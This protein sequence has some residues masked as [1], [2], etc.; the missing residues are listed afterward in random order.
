MANQL[1]IIVPYR[2]HGTWVF[3][4]QAVGLEREPFVTGVPEMIDEL[5]RDIPRADA[6]FRL[7]F[8]DRPFPGFQKELTWVREEYEGHWYRSDAPP[9]EGWLCPALL[10]YFDQAPRNIYVKAQPKEQNDVG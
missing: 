10:K 4:D 7:I 2:Y 8:S 1:Y 3:D 9:I 6:G 5:V